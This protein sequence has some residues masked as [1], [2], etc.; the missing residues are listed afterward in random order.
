MFLLLYNQPT[1]KIPENIQAFL[2]K[3][4]MTAEF[5][6]EDNYKF[7]EI[8]EKGDYH[9]YRL[10][11][12]YDEGRQDISSY[13]LQQGHF[14]IE[15]AF[16][17]ISMT[18]GR[19]RDMYRFNINGDFIY[20][21]EFE[22]HNTSVSEF[23]EVMDDLLIEEGFKSALNYLF[24]TK[25]DVDHLIRK[26]Y[27]WHMSCKWVNLLVNG[28]TNGRS[29]GFSLHRRKRFCEIL[30]DINNIDFNS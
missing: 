16:S 24:E 30:D 28:E 19:I 21:Y 27:Y 22:A 14:N 8:P 7:G 3:Y 23:F 2:D 26:A 9:A 6:V 20:R 29:E 13:H 18:C 11:L 12:T 10:T 17:E 15:D 25:K 5:R 4:G 1:M